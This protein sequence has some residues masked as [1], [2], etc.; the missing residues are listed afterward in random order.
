MAREKLHAC[1]SA[2]ALSFC[3]SFGSVACLCTAMDLSVELLGLALCCLLA[4]IVCA[5]LLTIRKGGWFLLGGAVACLVLVVFNDTFLEESLAMINVMFGYWERAYNVA[6]PPFIAEQVSFSHMM[7]VLAINGVITFVTCWTLIR[8]YPAPLALFLS[9]LPIALCCIVI[10]TVPQLFYL[11]LWLFGM[12]MILTTHAVRLRDAMQGIQLTRLLAIPVAA[13]LVLLSVLMPQST[14]TPPDIQISS[15]DDFWNWVNQKLPYIGQTS[16][17]DLVISF[18]TDL[19]ERLDL[20]SLAERVPKTTPVM[21]VKAERSGTLYL[22]G[23]DYDGYAGV[24][25]TSDPDREERNFTAPSDLR[26]S[27]GTVEILPLSHRTQQFL[28][29]YPAQSIPISGG[30]VENEDP[31]EAYS[32]STFALPGNWAYLWLNGVSNDGPYADRRYLELPEQTMDDAQKILRKIGEMN[33]NPLAKAQAI[34]R[35]V[36]ESARYDLDADRMPSDREDLAIWFLEEADKGYCVHFATSATVLLRAAGIPARYVEGYMAYTTAHEYTMVRE[37]S[38]HAWVEYFVQGIG[39]VI[40]DPTPSA[41]EPDPSDPTQTTEPVTEPSAFPTTM[42]TDPTTEP[43]DP[44]T[45]PTDPTTEPTDPTDPSTEPTEPSETLP[46]ETAEPTEPTEPDEDPPPKVTLPTWLKVT[47]AVLSS[48]IAAVALMWLQW[49]LRL[50]I[51]H[52][53]MHRG[54][55]NA[56][57]LAR[58]REA[59]RLARLRKCALPSRLIQLAEKASFSQYQ[60]TAEEL[61]V[62]DAFLRESIEALRQKNWLCRLFHRLIWAAY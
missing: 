40:L 14:Y 17:G 18:G 12:I 23:R 11:L 62:L 32:F 44:T 20:S 61:S 35:F 56:R 22:R 53:R 51:R 45:E 9:L 6:A 58:Y 4:S 27:S 26:V 48:I 47:V 59:R 21:E 57:A 33:D 13:A 43:T 15:F 19:P 39:W 29:Y 38:A 34:G 37:D 49:S 60:L 8:C 52:A 30:M 54:D 25:W 50:R 41:D 55:P 10:D 1:L 24:R 46:S 28:P 36:R 2:I 5:V 16:N 3:L 31:E 7:P 42:P